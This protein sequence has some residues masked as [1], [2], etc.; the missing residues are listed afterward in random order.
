M[1]SVLLFCDFFTAGK[2]ECC[3]ASI[4]ETFCNLF[5]RT[6]QPDEVTSS[7]LEHSVRTGATHAVRGTML[8]LGDDFEWASVIPKQSRNRVRGIVRCVF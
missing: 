8:D 5:G 3:T 1:Y 7:P 4:A 6:G 2:V